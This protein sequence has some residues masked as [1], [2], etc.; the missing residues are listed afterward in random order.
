MT[1]A[2]KKPARRKTGETRQ[3]ILRLAEEL[4]EQRGYNAFSYRDIATQLDIK[5]AAIHYYFKSKAD[6][7]EAV[8]ECYRERFADWAAGVEARSDNAW[9]WL[10]A[11]FQVY[12]DVLAGKALSI[13]SNGIL[14]AE[15]KTLPGNLQVQIR[16]MLRERYDWLIKTMR[17]GRER[18]QLRFTGTPET[19]AL[20]IAAATQGAMQI[21]Q[22][23]ALGSE[24]FKQV[25]EQIRSDLNPSN[26]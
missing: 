25:V 6:L 3:A 10:N 1:S 22:V 18:G 15:F 21:S 8:I 13:F 20:E 4:I 16:I 7:G 11:Y 14:S 19:K 17:L 23:V 5:N 12:A 2:A 9:D 26:S 24:R